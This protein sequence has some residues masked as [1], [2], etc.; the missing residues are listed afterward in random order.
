MDLL[1]KLMNSLFY[2]ML[3]LPL[4]CFPLLEGSASSLEITG[5]FLSILYLSFFSLVVVSSNLL[6]PLC[7]VMFKVLKRL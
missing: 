5:F 3:M 4:L 1:R 2:V 6:F 7:S